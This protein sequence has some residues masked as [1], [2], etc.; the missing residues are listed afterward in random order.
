VAFP[1]GAARLNA[2]VSTLQASVLRDPEAA[3]VA[4]GYRAC[5]ASGGFTAAG[6]EKLVDSLSFPDAASDTPAWRQ[7]AR[8]EDAA[9]ALDTR[10]REPLL[11]AADRLLSARL[12]GWRS[13][14]ATQLAAV[15]AGWEALEAEASQYD[16]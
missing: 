16:R 11:A 7:A 13:E 8:R 12:P 4:Q 10:C 9:A 6:P 3:R 15:Q 5:M 1:D 14:H 2:A